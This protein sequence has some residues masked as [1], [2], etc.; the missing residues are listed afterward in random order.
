MNNTQPQKVGV[1]S[2]W[3]YIYKR[4]VPS[5]LYSDLQYKVIIN[6][7]GNEYEET[8]HLYEDI[9]DDIIAIPR[10][11]SF[12]KNLINND[13]LIDNRTDGADI[14]IDIKIKPRDN[15]QVEAINSMIANDHGILCAKTAFGKTYVAI[16]VIATLK[17]RALILMHKRDLM[18]QWKDDILKYTN[19]TEEDIQIFTGS[20][21]KKNKAITITSVQNIG[22]K[23]RNELYDIRQEFL[24]ENFGIT[25]YDEC[26]TTIGPIMNSQSSRW[27]FSKRLFALSAT[28]TRGD[29][30]DKVIS[31]ILGDIIYIDNRKMLPVF[32]S[33]AP[34][35]IEVDNKAR[36]YLSFSQKQYTLRYNKWLTKQEAY[37][38]HCA[39]LIASLIKKN[40]KILAVAALKDTL[41]VIYNKTI[42]LVDSN[43]VKLIHGT[44]DEKLDSVKNMNDDDI[45]NFNCVFSTN[46]FFSEGI[47]INWLD[48]IIYLQSPSSKSLSSIPQLVG[49]IVREYK[50][51]R[52]VN[53]IDIY[54]GA[55]D[56]EKRRYK[57]RV[58]AYKRLQY[59][60]L[61]DY[62]INDMDVFVNH[63]IN[64]CEALT[65]ES[66][67]LI[68]FDEV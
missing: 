45:E 4:Y 50:N 19:L 15:Y 23:I 24:N 3:I 65:K 8:M 6:D 12:G 62:N 7:N 26:H 66:N 61:P 38:N 29:A 55:F 30:F 10:Y 32:V 34:V 60:I 40:K 11:C 58:E 9:N 18:Y 25:I 63:M 33:F 46:K 41:E 1:I 36:Y 31:C 68:P 13:M 64:S 5:N 22:A 49:R 20:N 43:K 54:N 39:N 52:Y 48:T 57:N 35:N 47:S 42:E 21:F 53:V 27:V 16:N 59:N 44:S 56:I 37:V 51:K 14:D 2:D 17:K 67:I 28:P